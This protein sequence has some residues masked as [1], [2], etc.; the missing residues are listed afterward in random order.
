V[1]LMKYAPSLDPNVSTLGETDGDYPGLPATIK[2]SDGVRFVFLR[3]PDATDVTY[4][5]E[6]C[7]DL[8]SWL[9]V[10][11]GIVETVLASGMIK[12]E[13]ALPAGQNGFC[14]LSVTR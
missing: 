6:A 3:N 9:P 8:K 5:V 14:R 7:D 11:E 1:N 2:S 10:T 12:V 13:V 4:A